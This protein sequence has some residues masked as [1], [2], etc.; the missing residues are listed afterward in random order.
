MADKKST[1]SDESVGSLLGEVVSDFE[2]LI[3]QQLELFGREI[4]Q[5]IDRAKAA[6]AE[7]AAGAGLLALSGV[8]TGQM[9]VHLLHQKSKLPLW[10]C[11]GIVAALAA[12]TGA[13]LL[14]RA[15]K[16]ASQVGRHTLPETAGAL[17]ENVA[18]L[19][20]QIQK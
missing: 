18:W 10:A 5:E 12:S 19:K 7:G 2:R 6:A 8:L 1:H 16:Q 4:H 3:A 20:H 9:L 14:R 15:G 17:R 13:A 11:H